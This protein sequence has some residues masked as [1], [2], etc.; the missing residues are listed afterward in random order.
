MTMNTAIEYVVVSYWSDGSGSPTTQ[1]ALSTRELLKIL[2]DHTIGDIHE[3]HEIE[4]DGS[5]TLLERVQ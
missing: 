1:T 2:N 4:D 5:L 3:V